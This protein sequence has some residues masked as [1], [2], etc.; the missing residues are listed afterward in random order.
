M[1][2]SK[3]ARLKVI[4]G[5]DNI[6]KLSLPNG[7]PESLEDLHCSIKTTFGIQ[8]NIRLQYMDQDF[9]SDFFNLNSTNDLK[10]LGTVKVI[11]HQTATDLST[12]EVVLSHSTSF[13]LDDTVSMAS[14]DTSNV[15]RKEQWP[16]DFAI[17]HFSFETELQL[18]HGNSE[19][20]ASGKLLTVSSRTK[21]DILNRLAEEIFKYKAYPDDTHFYIVAEALIKK[22]P[23]LKEPGSSSVWSGWKQRLKYKMGNYRTQL[24]MQG[25]VEVSVNSLKAKAATD[26][27]PAKKMKKPKRAEANFY[28]SLPVGQT[29]ESL[30]K[31]RLELLTEAEKRKNESVVREK[32]ALTFAYRR[33]EVVNQELSVRDF[34][35]RW[36]ALFRHY[37]INAEFHRLTAVPLEDTFF[38]QLDVHMSQLIGVIRAKGGA[39][40]EKTAGIF[41]ILDQENIHVKRECVLKALIVFLG[42]NPQ[43]LIKEYF[44]N[45]QDDCEGELEQLTMAVYVIRK[46][47]GEHHEP[48]ADI[49]VVIEGVKV[50]NELPSFTSA[51]ALLLGDDIHHQSGLSK[52]T[53]LYI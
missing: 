27:F 47:G 1:A 41:H 51:C 16:K 37:E 22:H 6:E 21:S 23:C 2:V 50:L 28:P 3:P 45:Q 12:T 46:E 29:C 30:E 10:D 35:A 14:N 34:R 20:L 42:E 19:Y 48:P 39:T 15:T 25:C 38:A 26:G 5:E 11:L 49:G 8:G 43:D 32:M 31:E 44:E 17:P 18:E 9:G 33:Q 36:P 13:D 52:T 24:K 53:S 7:I 40:R 4:L